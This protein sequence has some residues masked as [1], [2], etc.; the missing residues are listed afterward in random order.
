MHVD[1]R[2]LWWSAVVGRVFIE[3][4]DHIVVKLIELGL[5]KVGEQAVIAAM[6]VDDQDFLAAVAG[7]FVGGFLQQGELQV[8]AVGHGSR[9]VASLGDLAEIIFGKYDYVLLL[10]GVQRGVT[11][12]KQIG[13]ERQVW[14]MLFQN[15]EGEKTCPLG[16]M[17][18]FAEVGGGE[19]FPVD[20][21]FSGRRCS[22]RVN[23]MR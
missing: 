17:N 15:S 12:I 23:E 2:F 5:R 1:L 11:H 6:A 16:A 3:N 18:A 9:L 14:T 4:I 22:L 21:E 8:A 20:G 7:H 19:F 10:G 13:A